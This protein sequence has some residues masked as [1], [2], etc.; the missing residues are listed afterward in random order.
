M[1]TSTGMAPRVERQ[2]LQVANVASG[3]DLDTEGFRAP[4]VGVVASV[5]YIPKAAITGADTNTRKVTLYNRGQDGSGST[6]V[7][8]LQYNSGVNAVK[9]DENSVTL[10]GTSANLNVAEGDIL[11]WNSLHVG[12][13]LADPGGCV[14]VEFSRD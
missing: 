8:Q 11:T 3:S 14:V 2:F 4:F 10:S 9:W 13:G 5:K 1:G 12:T 7:A 6:V